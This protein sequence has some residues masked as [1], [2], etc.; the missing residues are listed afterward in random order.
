MKDKGIKPLVLP[1]ADQCVANLGRHAEKGAVPHNKGKSGQIPWNKGVLGYK[2]G[3]QNNR[4]QGGHPKCKDCGIALANYNATRC[5]ACAGVANSG[6]ANHAWKGGVTAENVKRRNSKEYRAWRRSVF[7]RDWFCCQMSGCGSKKKIEA[8][9]IRRF[10]DRPE[11][12]ADVDNGI[13]LCRSCH[14][15]IRNTEAQYIA[16]FEEIVLSKATAVAS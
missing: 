12:I 15:S 11:L 16:L 14:A 5:V 8:H 2:A 13:T 4:W 1:S 6:D 7:R 9:H 3:E 10:C